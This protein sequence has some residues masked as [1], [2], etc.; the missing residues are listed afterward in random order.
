[1]WNEAEKLLAK[2]KYLAALVKKW[3]PCTIRPKKHMDYFQGLVGDIIGQ[4]L[5]GRVADVIE[6][7]VQK[8]MKNKVT[9]DA[10]LALSEQSLRDCGMAWSKVRA[11][12]DLALRTKSGQL[13]VKSLDKLSD[14]EVRRELIAVKGIGPWTADMFLMF[15]LGR[16]DIFP[17]EDLGIKNGLRLLRASGSERFE[18]EMTK[19]EMAKFAER[20]KPFRTIASWYIWRSLENR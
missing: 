15:K 9:P 16:P 8:L 12:K 7:R 14:E 2:D 5:S 3:G 19:E 20:W 18:K 11:I 13:K 17:V 6:G 1:M 10:I 4:Q